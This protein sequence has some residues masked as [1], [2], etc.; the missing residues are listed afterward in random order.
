MTP[1]DVIELESL[2]KWK[3][4]NREMGNMYSLN[5]N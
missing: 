1:K 5:E 3:L 4:G 2:Y